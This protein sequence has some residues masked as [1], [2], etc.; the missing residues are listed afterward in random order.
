MTRDGTVTREEDQFQ[1]TRMLIGDEAVWRLEKA[2][3]LLFGVG[4]VGGFTCEALARAGI[5]MIHIVDKDVVDLTNLNRQIIATHETL[6]RPKVEVMAQRL[7]SINPD[8]KVIA[9][10]CF[11]LPE[12][13]S[14][15]DFGAYDYVVDA[16]DNVTAKLDIITQAK[17]AGVPV[18]SSMGTGNKLDPTRFE[19][20][21]IS[22]TSVCPL[23]KVIRK[24][25]K[26]RGITGVKVLYSKEEPVRTGLRTPASISFVPSAAG[27]IIAGQVIRD[28][29]GI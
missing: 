6:G 12:K 5:G 2:R 27:L 16:I 22:K 10:Q 3:V 11:Y 26:A 8:I 19:I 28:L 25:L 13:A 23:A 17:E 29:A 4:G 18:I 20:A 21:D 24:E 1:R 7:K 15:F 14:E 9:S